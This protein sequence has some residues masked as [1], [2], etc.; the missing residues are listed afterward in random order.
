MIHRKFVWAAIYSLLLTTFTIYTAMD[1]FVIERV[2]TDTSTESSLSETVTDIPLKTTP[3][4]VTKSTEP[5]VCTETEYQDE[6]MHITLTEYR[7]YDTAIY[8]ADVTLSSPADLK[9][10]FA[11]GVYGKNVTEKTSEIAA[12]VN[13]VLAINGDFYGARETGYVI[14]NGTLYRDTAAKNTEDLVIFEDGTFAVVSESETTAQSLLDNGTMQ[15]LSF[16]PG[17]V[18]D[19][20]I[21]VTEEE[22]VGKAMASNP[23][24]AIGMIDALHYMFVVS[25]GRTQESEGLSLHQLAEFMQSLGAETA[26]NLDGGGSATMVFQGAVVNNPTTNGKKIKERD[27]SDIVYI[28]TEP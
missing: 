11:K 4:A 23:R 17:L 10:A 6:T 19:G 15:V 22:E 7:E 12:E 13:A 25:D 5:I 9:T 21:A 28:G 14:R 18:I 27:V 1:T 3:T 24:T 16:G 20:N 2:Y 26:Y 8:V